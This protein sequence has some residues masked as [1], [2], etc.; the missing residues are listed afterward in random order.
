M[1]AAVFLS[2]AALLVAYLIGRRQ[3]VRG[4]AAVG[5]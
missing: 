2:T 5:S 4:L 1:M 3:L